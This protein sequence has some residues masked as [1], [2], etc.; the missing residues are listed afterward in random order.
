MRACPGKLLSVVTFLAVLLLTGCGGSPGGTTPSNP[1]ATNFGGNLVA[2]R[3]VHTATPLP[4][5][6][7]LLAGGIGSGG[8]A[9]ASAELYDSSA[10]VSAAA[11]SL[12]A[13]RY[14]H[15]ATLL[16]DGR[17][18]AVAGYGNAGTYI[19]SAELYNPSADSWLFAASLAVA[20]SGHTATLLQNGTVLV[21]GGYGAD[22]STFGQLLGL[23]TALNTCEIY[24]P[25]ANTWSAAGNLS[26]A[27]Y[28]HAATLLQDG[29]VLV[30]GGFDSTGATLASAEI[31]DPSTKLWTP[32]AGL[33]VPRAHHTA[34][35][36]PSGKVLAAAGQNQTTPLGSAELYDPAANSWTP[37]GAFGQ[38]T[39]HTA[40]LLPNGKVLLAAGEAGLMPVALTDSLDL[41]DPAANAWTHVGHIA[42]ARYNHTATLLPN[43]R[44]LIAGGATI[45]SVLNATELY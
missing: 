33:I 1:A 8:G 25:V 41:Y 2:A 11:A 4:N 18:L 12:G 24:D 30:A 37:A 3:T 45:T 9:L 5:G 21:A 14:G 28:G 44:V 13:A 36:L 35:L 20:R 23:S 29:R 39:G 34:T 10:N 31:Y 7:V 26:T 17:V 43:G 22:T 40:T 19:A 16:Q 32:A 6:K 42:I 27:R 15:T 38:R